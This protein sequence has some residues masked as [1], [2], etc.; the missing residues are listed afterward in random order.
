MFK[1]NCVTY[2]CF[3]VSVKEKCSRYWP[4][5]GKPQT[6]GS[7]VVEGISEEKFADYVIRKFSLKNEVSY[8][9]KAEL[10]IGFS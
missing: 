9:N 1:Y 8:L 6:W 3:I 4:E 5:K 10:G 7:F 2:T